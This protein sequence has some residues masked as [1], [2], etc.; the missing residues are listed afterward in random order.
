MQGCFLAIGEFLA[1]IITVDYAAS[2][3]EAKTFQLFQGGSPANVA[4]NVKFLGKD[5][6]LIS[7][8]GNDGIGKFLTHTL[9]SI[10][11]STN[12]IQVS[13]KH[14]TTIILVSKSTVSYTHLT[15]PTICSV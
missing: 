7:C 13:N 8:V 4:A 15:L 3:Q 14:A 2:L 11:I 9:T 6:E 5:V 1:D 10:G 12:H